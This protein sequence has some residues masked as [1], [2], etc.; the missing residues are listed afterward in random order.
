MNGHSFAWLLSISKNYK[1]AI[2][3]KKEDVLRL[4]KTRPCFLHN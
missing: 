3:N 4:A 2:Y 1:K